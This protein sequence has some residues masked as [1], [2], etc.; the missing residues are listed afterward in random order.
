MTNEV[1][2]KSEITGAQKH[3]QRVARLLGRLWPIIRDIKDVSR[4]EYLKDVLTRLLSPEAEFRLGRERV[5]DIRALVHVIV[6][7]IAR[8]QHPF[9]TTVDLEHH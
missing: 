2:T 5:T 3:E 4:L 8:Q 6:C 9:V 1:N 7:E